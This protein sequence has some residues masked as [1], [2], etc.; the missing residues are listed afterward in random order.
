VIFSAG[1]RT[2]PAQ[3]LRVMSF[4]WHFVDAV[5][6]VLFTVVYLIG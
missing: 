5:W 3:T 1:S 4:Y 6:V 2:P